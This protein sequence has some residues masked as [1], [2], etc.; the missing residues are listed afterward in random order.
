MAENEI[1][2]ITSRRWQRT[3]AALVKP[4]VSLTAIAE[5]V[6]E[7]L[8]SELQL[9]LA[10]A[11]RK[12]QTLLMVLQAVD[13]DDAAIR[14][15]VSTFQDGHLV[16]IAREAAMVATSKDAASIAQ[17]AAQMLIDGLINKAMLFA[18]RNG[19]FQD[20]DR[21]QALK[22][23]LRDEFSVRQTSLAGVIEASLNGQQVRRHKMPKKV[24]TPIS[25]EA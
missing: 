23:A 8:Q 19:C 10:N 15:A 17:C 4:D 22:S 1:L 24:Q 16:R 18:R 21:F 6:A 13:K 9:K 12:G 11:F 2:D 20:S 5:C 14:A 3:R 25:A 7:N